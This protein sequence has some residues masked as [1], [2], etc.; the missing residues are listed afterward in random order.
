MN[1]NLKYMDNMFLYEDTA[2]IVAINEENGKKIFIL[3]QS[4]FYPQGGGQPFDTGIIKKEGAEF[5]VEE[6]RFE[7]GIVKHIGTIT[8][9][10]FQTGDTV[11]LLIDQERRILNSRLHSAGHLIDAVVYLLNLDLTPAK[12]Y[13]FPDGP[14]VEYGGII[15]EAKREE[16]KSS[17]QNKVS[18]MIQEGYEVK[19]QYSAKSDLNK[20]CSF[21]PEYLP[22]NKPIR[23]IT[24]YGE[25]G[26]PCGGVH[27]QNINEIGKLEIKDLKSKKGNTRIRYSI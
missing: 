13:H 4:I 12:G 21:I 18:E 11:N 17:I 5:K 20:I 8:S 23:V 2:N 6:V 3:D 26:L 14:Y 7:N 19:S 27:V 1:T 22:E 24:V 10:E 25:L 15:D 16:I 9:G